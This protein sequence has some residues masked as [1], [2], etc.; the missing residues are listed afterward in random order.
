MGLSMKKAN[1]GRNRLPY[2][3]AFVVAVILS[4]VVVAFLPLE[5]AI[6]KLLFFILINVFAIAFVFVVNVVRKRK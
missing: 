2:I 5:F 1:G 3:L 4:L 6:K